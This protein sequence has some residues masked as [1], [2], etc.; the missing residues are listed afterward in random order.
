M[1]CNLIV[2]RCAAGSTLVVS[3][4]SDKVENQKSNIV[5]YLEGSFLDRGGRCD[6]NKED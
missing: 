1:A 3:K 5:N 2:Q 6:R 4:S